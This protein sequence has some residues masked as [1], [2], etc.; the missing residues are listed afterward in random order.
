M[1]NPRVMTLGLGGHAIEV[2]FANDA[3]FE[4]LAPALWL[5]NAG[6]P[7]PVACIDVWDSATTGVHPPAPPWPPDAI[8]PRGIVVGHEHERFRIAF[9]VDSQTL[10]FFDTTR[11]R[12][13]FWTRSVEDLR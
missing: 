5:T 3:V 4:A 11:Q 12:C 7:A 13:H 8:G 6:A 1:G 9:N 2:R 10:S